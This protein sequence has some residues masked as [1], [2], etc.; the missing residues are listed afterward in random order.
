MIN[1]EERVKEF[2]E[3]GHLETQLMLENTLINNL[4][5]RLMTIDP[6]DHIEFV[7]VRGMLEGL[8][9]LQIRRNE[10]ISNEDQ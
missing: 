1:L 9:R 8:Q 10:I 5:T 4:M 3:S 6:K 2:S 7:A